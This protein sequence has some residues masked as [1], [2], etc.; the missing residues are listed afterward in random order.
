MFYSTIIFEIV[1]FYIKLWNESRKEKAVTR[2]L[3]YLIAVLIDIV[4]KN[5]YSSYLIHYDSFT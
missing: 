4:I 2:I 1:T 5:R 3:E